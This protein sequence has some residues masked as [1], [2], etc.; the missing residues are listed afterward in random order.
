MDVKSFK[1]KIPIDEAKK[2]DTP[3]G[4]I[5]ISRNAIA[6]ILSFVGRGPDIA[7][8]MQIL[9]KRSRSFFIT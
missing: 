1:Q 3:F 9:T 2:H 7:Q 6:V 8:I 4:P 5:L